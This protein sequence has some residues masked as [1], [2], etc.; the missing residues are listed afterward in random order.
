MDILIILGIVC[1]ILYL[2][3][4]KMGQIDQRIIEKRM[5]PINK[6]NDEYEEKIKAWC[7]NNNVI[8]KE[9][10]TKTDEIWVN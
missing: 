5:E 3:A 10:I 4:K 9:N 1:I 8:F 7:N 6:M 2:F